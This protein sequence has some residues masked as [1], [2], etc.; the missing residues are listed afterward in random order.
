MR[1]VLY[2]GFGPAPACLNILCSP[3]PR[4]HLLLMLQRQ[5]QTPHQQ[6]LGMFSL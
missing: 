6:L 4:R 5:V 2:L 1:L 3:L